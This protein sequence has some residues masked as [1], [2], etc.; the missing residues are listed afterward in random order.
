MQRR[1]PSV[2]DGVSSWKPLTESGQNDTS[3]FDLITH[4]RL[5][6][7]RMHVS[8]W[9][10]TC[11]GVDKKEETLIGG[12]HMDSAVNTVKVECINSYFESGERT[13][14]PEGQEDKRWYS[15]AGERRQ[16]Y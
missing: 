4:S 3:T 16:Q 15:W 9:D 2:L 6:K 8:V 5:R 12:R 7:L 13:R 10:M 11:T 1:R 14:V